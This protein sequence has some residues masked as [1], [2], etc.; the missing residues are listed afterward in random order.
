MAG[1]LIHEVIPVG[2]LQCNCSILGDPATG[3]CIVV[4]PGDEIGRILEIVRRHGLKVRTIVSTHTHIDHVGGLP[5]LHR[6]TGAPVLIHRADLELYTNLDEQAQWLGV[7]T[8]SMM[9]IRDFVK[10][11]DTLRWGGY[12]ARVLH[13]PGHTQGSISLVVDASTIG[14]A[15]KLPSTTGGSLRAARLLAG[16]TLFQGS[17]GRTDLPGGSFPQI[18]SSIREK[19]LS[20]PDE[21][22]V[23]PGHGDTTT[24][25]AEREFNPFLR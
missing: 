4:D 1:K 24:I 18:L 11:G 10:D 17:I 7:P 23:Y 3:E 13:T 19:L 22:V 12:E 25:G 16:D 9:R 5:G 2:V 15:D 6:A 14:L 21:L 20:L 8:P